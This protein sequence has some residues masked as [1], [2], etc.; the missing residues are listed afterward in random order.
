MIN[1]QLDA[2]VCELYHTE[3]ILARWIEQ[4]L[5]R[6]C[7]FGAILNI[8]RWN[9]RSTTRAPSAQRG[10]PTNRDQCYACAHFREQFAVTRVKGKLGSSWNVDLAS[11][12]AITVQGSNGLGDATGTATSGAFTGR[13]LRDFSQPCHLSNS[14]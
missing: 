6:S 1:W 2:H 4:S 11:G 8:A 5:A 9:A 12:N 13:P 3:G 14:A 7:V 10:C